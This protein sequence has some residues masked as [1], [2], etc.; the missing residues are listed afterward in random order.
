[1]AGTERGGKLSRHSRSPSKRHLW[2]GCP[3]RG[4]IWE[5]G[6]ESS[7]LGR[8]TCP[9]LAGRVCAMRGAGL[10]APPPSSSW[11]YS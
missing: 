9:G 4:G 3:W 11:S 8:V 1:M 5:Q 10:A 6:H 2:P 7:G